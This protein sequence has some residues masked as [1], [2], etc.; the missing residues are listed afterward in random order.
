MD[1]VQPGKIHAF[2]VTLQNLG[3]EKAFVAVLKACILG[4]ATLMQLMQFTRFDS[5]QGEIFLVFALQDL[6]RLSD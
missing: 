5:S 1:V 3:S 2:F 6:P 4:K